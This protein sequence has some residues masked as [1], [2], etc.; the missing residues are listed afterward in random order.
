MHP[1]LCAAAVLACALGAWQALMVFAAWLATIPRPLMR[2]LALA[3]IALTLTITASGCCRH[4][5]HRRRES[6]K[7]KVGGVICRC[8]P[9]CIARTG[10]ICQGR[11]GCVIG[12]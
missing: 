4:D 7:P 2:R 8:G 3:A 10:G 9:I 1:A 6:A 11:C 5:R 12:H